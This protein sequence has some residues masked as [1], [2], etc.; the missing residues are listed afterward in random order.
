MLYVIINPS[1][2]RGGLQFLVYY[3]VFV[4]FLQL[5]AILFIGQRCHTFTNYIINT[6]FKNEFKTIT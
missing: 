4:S 6:A 2:W 3:S 5:E 1:L